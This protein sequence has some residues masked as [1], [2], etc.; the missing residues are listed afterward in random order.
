MVSSNPIPLRELPSTNFLNDRARRTITTKAQSKPKLGE[1]V[2]NLF[3]R[4]AKETPKPYNLRHASL[5][6]D[7]QRK[8]ISTT[9]KNLKQSSGVNRYSGQKPLQNIENPNKTGT[10]KI[11]N[12]RLQA[13]AKSPSYWKRVDADAIKQSKPQVVSKPKTLT[14]LAPLKQKPSTSAKSNELIQKANETLERTKNLARDY[15]RTRRVRAKQKKVG[16]GKTFFK[17]NWTQ[18]PTSQWGFNTENW[19]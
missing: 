18:K 6:D 16:K 15:D 17:E 2:Q 8:I 12:S 1:R 9:N 5:D 13:R 14:P 3:K 10:S 7:A 11:Y 19:G 4:K